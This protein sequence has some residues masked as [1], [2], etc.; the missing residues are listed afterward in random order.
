MGENGPQMLSRR[1]ATASL[2]GVAALFVALAG[3]PGP[4]AR[5]VLSYPDEAALYRA[6][7]V[8]I[9]VGEGLS[10]PQLTAASDVP[11]VRFSAHGQAPVIGAVTIGLVSFRALVHD[12]DCLH[13]L[14]G[15]T[16]SQ[17][18]GQGEAVVR[19]ALAPVAE[20]GC[21]PA[22]RCIDAECTAIDAATSDAGPDGAIADRAN[23]DGAAEDRIDGGSA[24]DAASDAAPSDVGV[25]DATGLDQGPADAATFDA[26]PADAGD[27]AIWLE[28][29]PLLEGG[30]V[31]ALTVTHDTATVLYAATDHGVY[32]KA[33]PTA[34]WAECDQLET[35]LYAIAARPDAP[36]VVYLGTTSE[37]YLSTD[38]CV[39]WSDTNLGR[40]GRVLTVLDD[41]TLYAG[42]SGGLWRRVSGS[43]SHVHTTPLDDESVECFAGD[44]SGQ[45]LLV[46]TYDSGL[47]RS[48]N[49]GTT[50]ELA[51]T[52]LGSLYVRSCAIAHS[53]ANRMYVVTREGLFRSDNGG[54]SWSAK[55]LDGYDLVAVSPIDRDAIFAWRWNGLVTSSDGG[56]SLSNDRR[57]PGMDLAHVSQ[58]VYDP[59]DPDRVYAATTRGVF[60]AA[61]SALAWEE[62]DDGLSVWNVE[63][64]AASAATQTIWLASMGGPLRHTASDGW[65]V[66]HPGFLADAWV[67]H[68]ALDSV[69]PNIVLT[70]GSDLMRSGNNG[71]GFSVRHSADTT[72][73]WEFLAA[74]SVGGE[75]FAG[76]RG[77]FWH[78]PDAVAA[79]DVH[80]IAGAA[81]DVG[82]LIVFADGST[83][84]IVVATN[85]G[86][87]FSINGGNTFYAA[88]TGLASLDANALVR[89]ASGGFLVGTSSGLFYAATLGDT[90]IPFG[91]ASTDIHDVVEHNGRLIV[92]TREYVYWSP[93]DSSNWSHIYGIRGKFPRSAAIGPAGE[94][95]IGSDSFGLFTSRFP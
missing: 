9:L 67:Q 23:R 77:R 68:V 29:V 50:W 86:V 5:L 59:V 41:R 83:T 74:A 26:A 24:R 15:C 25:E 7:R 80:T 30:P 64:I 53:D 52:G 65:Q 70:S 32:R 22:A 28:Q 2:S 93:G 89:L 73:G 12:S 94:L 88:N 3:C 1:R 40:T 11:R 49:R 47:V 18:S 31:W 8:E 38:S 63:E 46:G 43:W 48:S 75:I 19:I 87:F 72:D 76:S 91:F 92:V 45:V 69:D 4:Q 36:N 6:Q 85:S 61:N 42:T 56:D 71:T 54:A 84:Y 35:Q 33:S 39:S 82:E 44:A 13:F 16:E 27:A 58:L 62:I 21:G 37:V 81:R 66:V 90:W 79:G 95:L 34:P 57:S 78:W 20:Q 51:N 60:S 14:E 10:C 55:E 17:L